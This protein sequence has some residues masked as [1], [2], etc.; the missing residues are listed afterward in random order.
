MEAVIEPLEPRSALPGDDPQ[1]WLELFAELSAGRIEA[2][3]PL[4]DLAADRLHALALWRT[5]S[6]DIAAEVVQDAFVKLVDGRERLHRIADPR[7]WLMTVA[8]RL[9]VDRL[10]SRSRRRVVPL[11]EMPY[12]E[13]T[14][15]DPERQADAARAS[16]A[17]HR[18]PAV[19]RTAIY[20]HHFLGCT[21]AEVGRITRVPTFTAA[22]RYRNGLRRLRR[23]MEKQR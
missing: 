18:L 3:E 21:F 22:S 14:D 11:D 2:L 13:A 6:A 7:A 10:R 1:R 19:Q 17:L 16:A 15:R 8:Y 5:G 23:T 9:S 20:L 12:L 4:Y